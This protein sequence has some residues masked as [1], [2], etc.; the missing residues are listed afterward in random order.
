M[1]GLAALGAVLLRPVAPADATSQASVSVN[2]SAQ[3]V[4]QGATFD[5]VVQVSADSPS[6][7]AQVGLTF[8]PAVMDY[9][10]YTEGNFYSDWALAHSDDTLVDP[11]PAE[12]PA[13]H[14]TDF[15]VS[16]TGTT[17][18]GPTGSGTLVTFHFKAA[19]AN[20]MSSLHLIDAAV[21]DASGTSIPS[22]TANDGALYVGPGLAV[23]PS[24][25][26][27]DVGTDVLVNVV[28][29]TNVASRGA[30]FTLDF[31]PAVLQFAGW[32]QGSFYSSWAS[33]HGDSTTVGTPTEG[34]AGHISGASV[35]ITGSTGGGPTGSGTLYTFRFHSVGG[36]VSP[37]TL[38]GVTVSDASS[39]PSPLPSPFAGS[40]TVTVGER[41]SVSPLSQAVNKGQSFDVSVIVNS[42]L[43]TRGAQVGL[44]FD[45]AVMDYLGYTEGTFYSDW[46]LAHGNDTNVD[47]EPA[48]SSAG[49]ISDIGVYIT[50]TTAGGPTGSGTLAT[51]HFKAANAYNSSLLN[52]IDVRVSDAEGTS[53]SGVG[54]V[55]GTVWVQAPT[56]VG[57]FAEPPDIDVP[58]SLNES[59][60]GISS[61]TLAAVAFGLAVLGLV[62]VGTARHVSKKR[63]DN[64]ELES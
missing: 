53:I 30:Q 49:H 24:F 28:A 26:R 39:P 10:G 35:L 25:Q 45:P 7:G 3:T 52:L 16:V 47:P 48:E 59:V 43:P 11:E 63:I 64:S 8:D 20:D 44:T 38:G 21:S 19:N 42:A 61:E 13:G 2:P 29:A 18:G 17:T 37:I 56:T 23:S 60:H 27:S 57:G 46:A 62:L 14:I 54:V 36:G 55:G 51:F 12:N 41:V 31:N 34:P 15:A 40:G 50:G 6:R 32:T 33:A 5:V 22:V 9:L 1:L 4:S 58:L